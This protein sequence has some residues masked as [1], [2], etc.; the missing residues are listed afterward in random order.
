MSEV[1]QEIL[2][3]NKALDSVKLSNEEPKGSDPVAP[4]APLQ[5]L[6]M[7][8]MTDVTKLVP[9]IKASTG[10][11]KQLVS[12]LVMDGDNPMQHLQRFSE[13]QLCGP[14]TA[15][16]LKWDDGLEQPELKHIRSSP[17]QSR[18]SVFDNLEEP[19]EDALPPPIPL[20]P[21]QRS[22]S[23][24]SSF[25]Q[26]SIHSA[27]GAVDHRSSAFSRVSSARSS[28]SA[29][30]PVKYYA[31][32][33]EDMEKTAIEVT[34]IPK[35]PLPKSPKRVGAASRAARFLSDV[36]VLTRRRR[37]KV[38]SGRDNP[39][40]SIVE[41]ANEDEVECEEKTGNDTNIM[42]ITD[43]VAEEE[44]DG[45]KDDDQMDTE[46]PMDAPESENPNETSMISQSS[47]ISAIVATATK[48]TMDTDTPVYSAPVDE[49]SDKKESET[50]QQLDSDMD[51]EVHFQH[52]EAQL[53]SDSPGTIPSPSYQSFSNNRSSSTASAGLRIKFLEKTNQS[54]PMSMD[55]SNDSANQSPV[56]A[57]SGSTGRTTQGTTTSSLMGQSATGSETDREVMEAN[58]KKRNSMMNI[59]V[60]RKHESDIT[61]LHSSSTN[62]TTS[63]SYHAL[64]ASPASLRDGANMAGDR[65]FFDSSN[66]NGVARTLTNN[67]NS[68]RRSGNSNSPSTS[69]SATGTNATTTSAS[70]GEEPPKFVS[71]LDRV[72]QL[73]SVRESAEQDS[74][75]TLEGEKRE[76]SPAEMDEMM[77]E[78]P[79]TPKQRAQSS[80]VRP[81]NHRLRLDKFRTGSRPPRSPYK[82]CKSTSTPPPRGSPFLNHLSPPR[83]I[84]DHPNSTLISKPSVMRAL[85]LS[86][87]AS[88]ARTPDYDV[89][90]EEVIMADS[91]CGNEDTMK[92]RTYADGNVE[93]MQTS[94][95][96]ESSA[97]IVTPEKGA[98]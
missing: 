42:V 80:I 98:P 6:V 54:S 26:S 25:R 29:F 24:P 9:P 87:A 56:T 41:D 70:S 53:Q 45:D 27:F 31:R 84:V 75:R 3:K 30:D 10:T 35:E 97:T 85:E 72:A 48:D 46:E 69:V 68:S 51:E 28:S 52:V 13:M 59:P 18:P 34:D 96:E 88:P 79:V 5:S 95:T 78:E 64:D 89:Y 15:D 36:R 14:N 37:R 83:N 74:P 20:D 44:T 19:A 33:L 93:I 82:G 60:T 58:A 55:L 57:Q 67:S 66:P 86:G 61:S 2:V 4:T 38:R 47:E 12:T 40:E 21:F 1:E 63:R 76:A 43:Y 22:S 50:Y 17:L 90:Q 16:L 8:T 23:T 62:S 92:G 94:V 49:S 32:Q 39:I 77:F 73:M 81:T 7:E 91:N 71:Y 65:L 11:L